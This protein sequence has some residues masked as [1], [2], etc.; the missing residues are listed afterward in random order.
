MSE[1]FTELEIKIIKDELV[2]GANPHQIYL[3]L[4]KEG[5]QAVRKTVYNFIRKLKAEDPL[6]KIDKER[7]RTDLFYHNK[8][9]MNFDKMTDIHK[10]WRDWWEEFKASD[11][12]VGLFLV[13]RDCFKSTF[14]TIGASSQEI[15][16]NPNIRINIFNA[17]ENKSKE[18][19]G[20]IEQNIR[21]NPKYEYVY[22]DLYGHKLSGRKRNWTTMKFTV[23][24]DS[25][26]LA[27]PTVAVAGIRSAVAGR[28]CELIFWDD[29]NNQ[30]NVD[31]ES[32]LNKIIDNWKLSNALLTPEGK[33]L[34]I[35][36]KWR[37]NDVAGWVAD[38]IPQDIM[39]FWRS[40][41]NEDGKKYFPIE[42]QN[43][44]LLNATP[45]E[46]DETALYFPERLTKQFLGEQ[47]RK[48]G[49]YL[50][51]CQY[52]N[53]ALPEETRIFK[54]KYFRYNQNYFKNP[55]NYAIV[56]P[57]QSKKEDSCDTGIIILS[58]ASEYAKKSDGSQFIRNLTMINRAYKKKVS[59]SETIDWII[60]LEKKWK[61][62]T[63]WIEDEAYQKALKVALDL[64]MELEGHYFN[65]ETFKLP[66][67]IS[68]R[69]RIRG[70]EPF[71][72]DNT[73]EDGNRLYHY[74][75]MSPTNERINY[76]E[77]IEKQLL[78]FPVGKQ[79]DLI[80][81]E[82]NFADLV[83]YPSPE[84]SETEQMHPLIKKLLHQRRLRNIKFIGSKFMKGAR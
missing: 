64:K 53:N 31:Q 55:Y 42:L 28:H 10:E 54:K 78:R 33:G 84:H 75:K 18:F 56:D 81:A 16:N 50:F 13:P 60:K 39:V 52:K 22:G 80:D 1:T 20:V 72:E 43:S 61:F 77:D 47:L 40:C 69:T 17:V 27:D 9:V 48:L 19:L 5:C 26:I 30:L 71:Y 68:K 70:L 59:I 12:K 11:K 25:M 24:R 23:V 41:Y 15:G 29:L 44:G 2:K 49:S 82:A 63:V 34:I 58:T 38:N 62:L 7:A 67:G 57:A 32:V 35:M 6:F 46:V 21:A 3:K 79:V 74:Y 8:Y 37:D 73:R 51:N 65:V 14:F 45:P 76:C 36:T 66:K 83:V 4:N